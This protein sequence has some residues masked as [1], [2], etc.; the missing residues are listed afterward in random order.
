[1]KAMAELYNSTSQ[2]YHEREEGNPNH[3][4]K[5]QILLII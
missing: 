1:M 2:G 4:D 3:A 5:V